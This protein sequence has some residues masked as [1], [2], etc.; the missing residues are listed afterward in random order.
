MLQHA[1]EPDHAVLEHQIMKWYNEA[2]VFCRERIQ[3]SW[4]LPGQDTIIPILSATASITPDD[5]CPAYEIKRRQW[6]AQLHGHVS[7]DVVSNFSILL[8]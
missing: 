6:I 8:C 2:L 7:C 5:E 1:N 3:R 4:A